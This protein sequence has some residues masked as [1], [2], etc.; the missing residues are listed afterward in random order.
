MK[1]KYLSFLALF[2]LFSCNDDDKE[3]TVEVYI[4]NGKLQ[5]Q[6]NAIPINITKSYLT[7]AGLDFLEQS[8][9]IINAGYPTVC[10]GGT[11]QIHIYSISKNDINSA[12]NI[13]FT[14]VSTLE[15]GYQ[16]M[17][18]GSL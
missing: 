6:D 12:T 5:C 18:C 17:D 7:N 4:S 3:K 1:I 9:G 14:E 16:S 2:A 15:D 8:C 13:G 11:G 10:G